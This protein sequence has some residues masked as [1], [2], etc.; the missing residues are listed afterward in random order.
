MARPGFGRRR[1]AEPVCTVFF[2]WAALRASGLKAGVAEELDDGDASRTL[3]SVVLPDP[4]GPRIAV[5]SPTPI[6]RLMSL[7]TARP[8]TFG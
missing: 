7:H 3:K 8:P 6:S 5:N 2:D 4:F 1:G